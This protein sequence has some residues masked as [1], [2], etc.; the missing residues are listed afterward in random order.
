MDALRYKVV[1]RGV[2][3][4][5]SKSVEQTYLLRVF[6]IIERDCFTRLCNKSV[7]QACQARVSHKSAP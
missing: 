3:D 7:E 5:S 4:V 2:L 6:Q 1:L